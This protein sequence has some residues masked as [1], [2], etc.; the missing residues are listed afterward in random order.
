DIGVIGIDLNTIEEL[1]IPFAVESAR[2]VSDARGSLTL[3]PLAAV[4]R[5]D[6]FSVVVFDP[7]EADDRHKRF[8]LC[9][10]SFA[11]QIDGCR[12]P[13]KTGCG[14]DSEADRRCDDSYSLA[15]ALARH[16][17]SSPS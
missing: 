1:G 2:L 9:A 7:P 10:D 17:G 5:E 11:G 8:W 4:D 6:L 12:L 16:H 13:G 3:F 14:Q 15:L